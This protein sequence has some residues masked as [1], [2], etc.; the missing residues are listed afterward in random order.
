M[1]KRCD[2]IKDCKDGSDEEDCIMINVPQSYE[3]L[4]PPNTEIGDAV[5]VHVSIVIENINKIDT[6][7]MIV[8]T[9]MQIHMMW[10]DKRLMFRNL[11]KGRKKLIKHVF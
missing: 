11:P 5:P 4:D 7:N 10:T 3:K 2:N 6:V 8:D 9:S 1:R